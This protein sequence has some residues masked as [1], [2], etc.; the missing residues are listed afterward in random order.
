MHFETAP[1]D[2]LDSLRYNR[3][4]ILMKFGGNGMAIKVGLR[5]IEQWKESM[6][7]EVLAYE[8]EPQEKGQIVFYGPSYFTRWGKR[9]GMKPMRDVL[10]G[11]SGAK[12]V[13]NRG[14]GSSCSEHQLYYYP[15]LI[16]P[17]APKVLVYECFGNSGAFGYTHDETWELAQRVLA[18]A[19]TDFPDIK[20]YLCGP[21]P[22][23]DQTPEKVA[24]K[25][26]FSQR[27]KD[28]AAETPNCTYIDVLHYAPLD[29]KDI[30][31]EDGVHFNQ[32]G[33]DIY[34]DIYLEALKEELNAF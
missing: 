31:V 3:A 9:F 25:E 8:A 1:F 30:Y 32:M 13:V 27:L 16:R 22:S 23:R 26:E 29:R 10:L 24:A 17:L 2:Y 18:Y 15:R 7:D 12:C 4:I 21:H 14:F 33:Y 5:Y 6:E 28:Y 20:I 11:K 19:R 34:K